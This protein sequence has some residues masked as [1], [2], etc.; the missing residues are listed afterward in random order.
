MNSS[1]MGPMFGMVF[2]GLLEIETTMASSACC[3]L[4]TA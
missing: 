3:Y 4:Q 2:A 1:S